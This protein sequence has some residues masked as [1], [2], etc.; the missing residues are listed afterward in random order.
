MHLP[1]ELITCILLS[2]VG[3]IQQMS[4]LMCNSERYTQTVILYDGAAS[5]QITDTAQFR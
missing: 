4:Q 2:I 1:V 3:R 5:T